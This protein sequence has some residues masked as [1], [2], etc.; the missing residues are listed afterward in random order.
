MSQPGRRQW[1]LLGLLSIGLAACDVRNDPTRDPSRLPLGSTREFTLATLGQ[2][3][4]SY[5]LESGERLQYSRAPSG[6]EVNNVDLD[7]SGHVI[8]VTQVLDERRFAA[9]IQPGVW[10]EEDVERTYGKPARVSRVASFDGGI[11]EWRYKQNNNPRILSIYV[12]PRGVVQRY[13]VSDEVLN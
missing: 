2:P 4:A 7:A 12:D 1:L 10:T 5:R 9:T 3:T 11:W 13:Q 6:Y 8:A